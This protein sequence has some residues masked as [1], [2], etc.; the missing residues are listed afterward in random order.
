METHTTRGGECRRGLTT[1]YVRTRAV[2]GDTLAS[3]EGLQEELGVEDRGGRVERK[4]AVLGVN[5]IGCSNGVAVIE[6]QS[7]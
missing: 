2:E 4:A 1:G 7:L 3:K 5:I 6:S